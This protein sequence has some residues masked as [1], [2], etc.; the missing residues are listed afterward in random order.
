[1]CKFVCL[2]SCVFVFRLMCVCVYVS[3]EAS[4]YLC[5]EYCIF[6]CVCVCASLYLHMFVCVFECRLMCVCA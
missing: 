6:M 4:L 5:A 3:V 1:M 2:G